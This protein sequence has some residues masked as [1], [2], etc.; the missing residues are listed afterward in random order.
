MMILRLLFFLI[1]LLSTTH[2]N[3]A[4]AAIYKKGIASDLFGYQIGS[5]IN[6]DLSKSFL[7]GYINFQKERHSFEKIDDTIDIKNEFLFYL[8][9]FKKSFTPKYF[10]IELDFC[11]LTSAGL[12]LYEHEKNIYNDFEMDFKYKN[13]GLQRTHLNFI[14]LLTTRYE[15][16]YSLSF[17][18]GEI[19]TF[20]DKDPSNTSSQQTGSAI[21]GHVLTVGNEKLI[22]MDQ[23]QNYW[24][25]YSYKIKGTN[26][27][28][29]SQKKW[30]FQIGYIYNQNPLF[31]D[32]VQF[33]MIRDW[34]THLDKSLLANFKVEYIFNI[35]VESATVRKGIEKITS[36]QKI[37]L[38]RN[39]HFKKLIVGI[40]FGI[41]WELFKLNRE[42]VFSE[43]SVILAPNLSW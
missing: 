4:Q 1:L 18:L 41:K 8:N 40:D 25:Q 31:F 21:M 24:F 28:Q 43:T 9:Q 11:P 32:A 29:D 39:F 37:I 14:E 27:T 2:N 13:V 26:S 15:Y 22:R 16:P 7:S 5:T 12:Y 6:L 19:L 42:S 20:V 10:L 3:S 34:T 38:G 17:F 30:G 36:F 35:P 23:K 33:Q